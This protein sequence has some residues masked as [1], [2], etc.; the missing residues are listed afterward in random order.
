MPSSITFQSFPDPPA[1]NPP[2][3]STGKAG[4]PVAASV[5]L[6]ALASPAVVVPRITTVPVAQDGTFTI[7]LFGTD[8]RLSVVGLPTGYS[9]VSM[10]SGGRNLLSQAMEVKPGAELTV[11][12]D[13]GD[14]RPRYR[15]MALVRD[16]SSDRP[17]SG[18]RTELVHASGEVVRFVNAQGL[19]TFPDLLPGTYVLRLASAGFDVPEKQV[20]ITNSSVQVELRARRKP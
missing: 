3:L 11:S 12:L 1:T 9:V 19:V 4:L 17:L 8:Q 13:V 7:D 16:D 14:V 2:G 15:L 10:T 5:I 18:E 6:A 20:V